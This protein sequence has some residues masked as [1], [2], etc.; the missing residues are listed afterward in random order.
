MLAISEW[1]GIF[2]EKIELR[3]QIDHDITYAEFEVF[4]T[5]GL[6]LTTY[7]A[8]VKSAPPH[9][10]HVICPSGVHVDRELTGA[11]N[12]MLWPIYG[13][14]ASLLECNNNGLLCD[15]VMHLMVCLFDAE[16]PT[17]KTWG[18]ELNFQVNNALPLL[19]FPNLKKTKVVIREEERPE[20]PERPARARR[21]QLYPHPP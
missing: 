1:L 9:T 19:P 13:V 20:R 10:R 15:V 17:F 2:S 4:P 7:H 12:S 16:D 8:F 14:Q 21:R 6:S 18:G 3:Q 11:C 5:S